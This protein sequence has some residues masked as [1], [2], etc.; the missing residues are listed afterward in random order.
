MSRGLHDWLRGVGGLDL[1]SRT[2]PSPAVD[3]R[4]RRKGL[5]S[6]RSCPE[7][8]PSGLGISGHGAVLALRGELKRWWALGRLR[9]KRLKTGLGG[10]F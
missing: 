1:V 5:L 10:R 3:Q 7:A 9:V 4:T 6:S 2:F 8:S